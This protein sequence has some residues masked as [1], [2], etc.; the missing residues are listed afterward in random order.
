MQAKLSAHAVPISEEQPGA[1]LLS[2]LATHGEAGSNEGRCE[3]WTLQH[4]QLLC[5]FSYP[6]FL[7]TDGSVV[8]L[9]S[10]MM[11]LAASTSLHLER[12]VLHALTLHTGI[13]S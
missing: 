4:R 13:S 7:C 1:D 3:S 5:D 6:C 12:R 11:V 9:E 10:L 2:C 8:T